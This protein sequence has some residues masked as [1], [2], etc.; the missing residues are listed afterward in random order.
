MRLQSAAG[1][2][3]DRWSHGCNREQLPVASPARPSCNTALEDGWM[4]AAAAYSTP[5][6]LDLH[7]SVLEARRLNNEPKM[8]PAKAS[9]T[10]PSSLLDLVEARAS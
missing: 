4:V 3:K 5:V 6:T 10:G 8:E 7:F 2:Q 9:S 1:P